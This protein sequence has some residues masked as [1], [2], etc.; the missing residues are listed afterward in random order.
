MK[1][2][3]GKGGQGVLSLVSFIPVRLLKSVLWPPLICGQSGT[4]GRVSDRTPP[5]PVPR[6]ACGSRVAPPGCP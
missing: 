5:S 6:M 1:V 4:S 3:R 2:R